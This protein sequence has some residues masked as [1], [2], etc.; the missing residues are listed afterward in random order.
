MSFKISL[1]CIIKTLPPPAWLGNYRKKRAGCYQQ[2]QELSN[3][4]SLGQIRK[5][6]GMNSLT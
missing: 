1:N 5:T 3:A 4:L 2:L 6:R